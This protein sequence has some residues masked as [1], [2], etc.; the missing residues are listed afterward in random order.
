MP[1]D[2]G[3]I[4]AVLLGADSPYRFIGD[5]LYIQFADEDFADLCPRDGQP[6]ISPVI[7]YIPGWPLE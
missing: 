4:G 2:T 1:E 3:R 7:L 6:T 5:I